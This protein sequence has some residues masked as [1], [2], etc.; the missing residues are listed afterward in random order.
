MEIDYDWGC[1]FQKIGNIQ[2]VM[3][4]VVEMMHKSCK[5]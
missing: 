3:F 1:L 2:F 4:L 5:A